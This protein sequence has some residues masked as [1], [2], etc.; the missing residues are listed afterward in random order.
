MGVKMIFKKAGRLFFNLGGSKFFEMV[1]LLLIVKIFCFDREKE[2]HAE[3]LKAAYKSGSIEENDLNSSFVGDHLYLILYGGTVIGSVSFSV[4]VQ[5]LLIFRPALPTIALG[6]NC[7]LWALNAY[8]KLIES[9]AILF[10][11]MVAMGGLRQCNYINYLFLAN[12]KTELE[13]D[14]KLIH[15]ERELAVNFLLI[16]SDLG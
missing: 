14:M 10:M 6:I 3:N 5:A 16:S 2:D 13:F 8:F 15:Q 7:V 4:F 12:A 9:P 11:A 1:T